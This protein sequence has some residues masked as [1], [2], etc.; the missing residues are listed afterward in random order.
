MRKSLEYLGTFQ[1]GV[2]WSP[3]RWDKLISIYVLRL[4][5][6]TYNTIYEKNDSMSYFYMNDKIDKL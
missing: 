6:L 4:T 5:S 1:D 2:N 3:E